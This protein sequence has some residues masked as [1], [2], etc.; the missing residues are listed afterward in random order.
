MQYCLLC[1]WQILCKKPEYRMNDFPS[2]YEI[3]AEKLTLIE[4]K[5]K[6]LFAVNQCLNHLSVV[7]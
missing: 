6:K 3:W 5:L 1:N 2:K 4:M 7:D